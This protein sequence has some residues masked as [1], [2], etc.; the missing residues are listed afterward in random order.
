MTR[1][2]AIAVITAALPALD[3]ARVAA[4]ADMVQSLAHEPARSLDLTDDELAAIERS[5]EDFKAGRTLSAEVYRDEM[6]AFMNAMAAKYP[7]A[8]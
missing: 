5:K 7:A 3:D 6:R 4:V 8:R 1:S 2:E